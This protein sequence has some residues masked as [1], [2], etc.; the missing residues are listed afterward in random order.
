MRIADETVERVRALT[1]IVALVGEVVSLRASGRNHMGLCPFHQERT[2][3]FSVSPERGIYHCFGCGKGGDVFAFIM[4]TQGVG[5]VDALRLLAERAGVPIAET[6]SDG[7]VEA[8]YRLNAFAARTYQEILL[9]LPAGANAR[10]YARGRGYTGEDIKRFGLGAAPEA[11]SMLG[12]L[13]AKEGFEPGIL[14]DSGLVIDRRESSGYYDRFR[15][16]LM[17]PIH[18]LTGRVVAFG[19]RRLGNDEGPK[20]I[21]SP[22]TPVYRK[23]EHLFGLYAARDAIREHRS[24]VV[25]EGYTDC[26]AM[27]RAGVKTAVA[28]LGTAFTNRQGEL[29]RRYADEVILIFDADAAG[30]SAARKSMGILLDCGLSVRSAA[31]PAGEDPDSLLKAKGPEALNESVAAHEDAVEASLRELTH[32]LSAAG[33]LERI[34]AVGPLV[35]ALAPVR[36]AA[37]KNAYFETIAGRIRVDPHSLGRSRP[38]EAVTTTTTK[39]ATSVEPGLRD[40][41]RLA[42]SDIAHKVFARISPELIPDPDVRRVYISLVR[43]ETGL[44]EILTEIENPK[45]RSLLTELA[46]APGSFAG[47]LDRL[48]EDVANHLEERRAARR[49]WELNQ[50]LDR[51]SSPERRK[52]ILQSL[53][54]S[55]RKKGKSI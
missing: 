1:D 20:Y 40:L 18:A 13:A 23:G 26:L 34:R 9:R 21:N 6:K 15:N 42:I 30:R 2:P 38:A 33:P 54:A 16:R 8:L 11:W 55:L 19:G 47:D 51:T 31:L 7:R 39:P 17:F 24:A 50:E 14:R 49:R 43:S 45:L 27:Q 41:L 46:A 4:E 52:E 28:A 48:L 37:L 3:S 12:D 32:G 35:E 10:R 22:E 44:A 53:S 25:V 5:F 36:D 29:L